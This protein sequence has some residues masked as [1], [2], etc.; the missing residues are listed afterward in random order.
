VYLTLS[1]QYLADV[2]VL[3]FCNNVNFSDIYSLFNRRPLD[4]R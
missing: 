1:R 3:V 2:D 4:E